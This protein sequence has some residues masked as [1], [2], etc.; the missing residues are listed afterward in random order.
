MIFFS[1]T[2]EESLVNVLRLIIDKKVKTWLKLIGGSLIILGNI[3]VNFFIFSSKIT[4]KTQTTPL[5]MAA[6]LLV[7]G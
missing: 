4:I 2:A 1:S 3:N 7:K 5:E 6:V